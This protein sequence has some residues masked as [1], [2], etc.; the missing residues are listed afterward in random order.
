MARPKEFDREEALERALGVFWEKGYEATSVGDLVEATGVQRQ[1]LYDTFGDKHGL[2]RA[3]LERY[4]QS[5]AAQL[6]TLECEGA[7]GSPLARLRR[8]FRALTSG[9]G[10]AR[11]GCLVINSAVERGL[12]DEVVIEHARTNVGGLERVF[13]TLILEAQQAGEVPKT[14]SPKAAGRLLVSLFWGLAA[15]GRALPDPTW[16]RSVID[17]ALGLIARP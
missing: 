4:A 3:A 9:S 2:F 6:E 10:P 14:T 13:A 15:M 5:R 1:S 8:V 11:R 7:G 12:T 17:G 16:Q